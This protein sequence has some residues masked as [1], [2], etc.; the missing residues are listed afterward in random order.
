MGPCGKLRCWSVFMVSRTLKY[1]TLF[2]SPE[3]NNI[4]FAR[5]LHLNRASTRHFRLWQ[6]PATACNSFH[7]PCASCREGRFNHALPTLVLVFASCSSRKLEP[8]LGKFQRSS[9]AS[10]LMVRRFC[11]GRPCVIPL[12]RRCLYCANR[13]NMFSDYKR[14][15]AHA[16][17]SRAP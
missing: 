17:R 11:G 12:L 3:R 10:S 1:L 16:C 5:M 14:S 2:A 4:F 6:I 15:A 13:S 7:W 9:R 8:A